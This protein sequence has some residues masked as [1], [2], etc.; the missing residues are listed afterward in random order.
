MSGTP[1]IGSP[2]PPPARPTMPTISS[3]DRNGEGQEDLDRSERADPGQVEEHEE[4]DAD[5]DPGLDREAAAEEP[6]D[7]DAQEQPFGGAREELDRDVADRDAH[8]GEERADAG[9][10]VL[11]HRARLRDHRRELGEAH[12]LEV[13]RDEADRERRE[14]D[15]ARGKALPDGDQH[16]DRPRSG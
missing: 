12:A 4:A 7:H 14:E 1:P 11:V 5:P 16:S 2:E 3:E 6:V 15:P 9:A 8:G 13:H 10:H